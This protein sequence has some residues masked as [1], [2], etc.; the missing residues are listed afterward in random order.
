MNQQ[1]VAEPWQR[2]YEVCLAKYSWHARHFHLHSGGHLLYLQGS[3]FK[4]NYRVKSLSAVIQSDLCDRLDD[5]RW[6]RNTF[7]YPESAERFRLRSVF[8]Q[9]CILLSDHQHSIYI[10]RCILTGRHPADHGRRCRHRITRC[11][12][13]TYLSDVRTIFYDQFHYQCIRSK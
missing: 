2:I 4:W 8:L 5:R 9:C 12:V 7:Y 1:N 3:R 13:C 10:N 11:S 6:L